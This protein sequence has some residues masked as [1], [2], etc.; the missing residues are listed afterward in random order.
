MQNYKVTVSYDG[1][2]YHGWQRQPGKRTI[3]GLLENTLEK[4]VSKKV[5]VIGSG[6]TDAGVHAAGQVA[7]FKADSRLDDGEFLRAFNGILPH[8]IR[9][10]S[11]KKVSPGFHAR[12]S[13]RSKVYCYRI[14][15]APDISPF[16]LRY[17]LHWPTPLDL[18]EMK[19]GAEMFVREADFTPFSSNRLPSPVRNVTH[20]E[21]FKK[22]KD[23]VYTVEANGFLR[24]MVR[25]MVGTLLEVGRG[26]LSPQKIQE[27]FKLDSRSRLCP[28]APAKGLT[29]LKVKY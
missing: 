17:V 6:R 4:I 1:T 9:V 29:L 10:T 15:N 12:K 23:L 5:P 24:Y 14:F 13:A 21:I 16:V 3:Q 22:G 25:C 2:D 20:S 8:D 19:K 7:H 26:K 27:F 11:L 28:T 18:A